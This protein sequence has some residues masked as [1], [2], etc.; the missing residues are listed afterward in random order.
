MSEVGTRTIPI[1]MVNRIV[2]NRQFIFF[3]TM[4]S[5]KWRVSC[6]QRSI[7]A[8]TNYHEFQDRP[9]QLVVEGED[10]V[11]VKIQQLTTPTSTQRKESLGKTIE[12]CCP[13][14]HEISVHLERY[15]NDLPFFSRRLPF[16]SGY[17]QSHMLVG[18][19][20]IV[21]LGHD[22]R[23]DL[24]LKNP[25]LVDLFNQDASRADGIDE[26]S[27]IARFR[28]NVLDHIHK[29]V[30]LVEASSIINPDHYSHE[31]FFAVL[32]TTFAGTGRCEDLGKE[33]YDQY[34]IKDIE[35]FCRD[36][37]RLLRAVWDQLETDDEFENIR[38]IRAR[39]G[40]KQ[41]ATI[42]AKNPFFCRIG[43][44]P[45]G[46]RKHYLTEM[47]SNFGNMLSSSQLARL[48]REMRRL[49]GTPDHP[50]TIDRKDMTPAR[51]SRYLDDASLS[52]G[53]FLTDEE[54]DS[55]LDDFL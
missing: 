28:L 35:P 11:L 39:E 24:L 43:A 54:R 47:L 3:E 31:K 27:K 32:G 55:G 16:F 18:Q 14:F 12:D 2:V 4:G 38:Q 8:L 30:F 9:L 53:L 50:Y 5:E 19:S 22:R 51:Y 6:D 23:T 21:Q 49:G 52:H 26:Y 46:G 41:G 1:G 48:R 37:V 20:I 40:L 7:A 29:N 45:F 36:L 33:K 15:P 17:L 42:P 13:Y 10:D 34:I 25:Y 44:R